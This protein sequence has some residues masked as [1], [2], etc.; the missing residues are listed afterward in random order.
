MS[1]AF[2][3]LSSMKFRILVL[4]VV[5]LAAGIDDARPES[6]VTP[7]YARERRIA[8]QIEPGIFDG[9]PVWLNA[10]GREFLS[11]HIAVEDPHGAVLL[12]HGRDV[13][14]EEQELIGPLRV[15]LAE[16]GW[17]TLALQM[18]VLA[19]GSTYHD[20]LPVLRFAHARIEAGI[21]YLKSRG[22]QRIFLAAHSCGAH[23]A[24]DWFNHAGDPEVDGYIAMGLGATDAGQDLRTPFPIGELKI[25]VL[26]IYGSEEFPRP[27]EMVPA[28]RELLERNGH[29]GSLQMPVP[30]ADHYFRGYGEEM[31]RLLG[32]WLGSLD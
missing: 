16:A 9:E 18:P 10:G 15:G 19:K 22:A 30:G 17:T 27:L 3:D 28:R 21:A 2:H 29:S 25:P 6:A 20:Y 26:D 7:D 31:T 1:V 13:S 4:S 24:N 8:E 5:V 12:L 14:P 23:M 11:V 32:Q